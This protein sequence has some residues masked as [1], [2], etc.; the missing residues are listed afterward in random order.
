MGLEPI[1]HLALPKCS[2]ACNSGCGSNVMP[3]GFPGTLAG[4]SPSLGSDPLDMKLILL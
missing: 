4:G 3:F 1:L 2:R